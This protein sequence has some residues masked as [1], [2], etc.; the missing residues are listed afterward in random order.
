[1]AGSTHCLDALRAL[2]PALRR[3]AMMHDLLS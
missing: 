2:L 3:D 1:M